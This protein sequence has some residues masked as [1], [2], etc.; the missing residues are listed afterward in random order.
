MDLD[1]QEALD[2]G[3]RILPKFR[4]KYLMSFLRIG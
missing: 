1:E 4:E 2:H 3:M